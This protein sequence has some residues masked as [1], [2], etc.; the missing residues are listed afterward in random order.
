[1]THLRLLD[2]IENSKDKDNSL[3]DCLCDLNLSFIDGLEREQVKLE[4]LIRYN[5]F[6]L[7]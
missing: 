4:Q 3:N 2:E 6:L 7:Q 1:M 5:Q